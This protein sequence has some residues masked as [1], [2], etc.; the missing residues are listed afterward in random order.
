MIAPRDPC[1]QSRIIDGETVV[2]H[3]A[4][5]SR[6]SLEKAGR[7]VTGIVEEFGRAEDKVAFRKTI[8]SASGFNAKVSA[9][10]VGLKMTFRDGVAPEKRR[11]RAVKICAIEMEKLLLDDFTTY[12]RVVD[13]KVGCCGEQAGL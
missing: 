2:A 11:L 10:R 6:H 13:M 5:L 8:L 4:C 1:R 7:A 3:R 9:L 12:L